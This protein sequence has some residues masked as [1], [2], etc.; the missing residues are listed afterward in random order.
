M[1]AGIQVIY[2][3]VLTSGEWGGRT[4]VEGVPAIVEGK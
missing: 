4:D 3:A 1:E 2:Q